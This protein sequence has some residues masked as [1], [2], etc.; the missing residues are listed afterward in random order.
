MKQTKSERDFSKLLF[1]FAG[2]MQPEER[3]GVAQG[4]SSQPALKDDWQTTHY[5]SWWPWPDAWNSD[6]KI[7]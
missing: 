1:V 4:A 7:M 5:T 3:D 2:P 6:R